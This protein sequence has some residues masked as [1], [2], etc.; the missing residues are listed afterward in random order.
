M[1]VGPPQPMPIV[2][3]GRRTPA[4]RSSSSMMI[5]WIGSASSPHGLGQCG[6]TYPASASCRP[7][8]LGC[9]AIHFLTWSRRGSSSGGRSK[10]TNLN[11]SSRHLN[12]RQGGRA[13]PGTNYA[14]AWEAIAEVQPDALAQLQGARR[15]TWAEFDKRADA[16]A[17]AMLEVD[18]VEKQAKVAQYL[19]NCPEYLES[20]YGG[21]KVGLVPVNTNFR[22]TDDELV[23]LWDNA[24]AIAVVF[25][26][27]FTP[28]IE[29]IKSKVPR[30]AKWFWVDDD[31]SAMPDWAVSYG[32]IVSKP[33]ERQAGSWGRDG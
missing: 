26:G 3:D 11:L 31:G 4:A 14:D 28:T 9:S 15:F 32:E 13:M 12:D 1:I 17:A 5:W 29:R 16:F 18:G 10:S 21:W 7:V 24:D 30:V 25:H 20:V 22:Y 2:L 6:A 33:V 27:S 23:Y 8:G 19:Q